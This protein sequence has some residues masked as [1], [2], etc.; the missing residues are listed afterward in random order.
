MH[1]PHALVVLV[2]LYVH[3]ALSLPVLPRLTM[4]VPAPYVDW[5]DWFMRDEV[6]TDVG[7][8]DIRRDYASM[9]LWDSADVIVITW[10]A[11][12]GAVFGQFIVPPRGRGKIWVDFTEESPYEYF[13]YNKFA[14]KTYNGSVNVLM[15]YL[16]HSTLYAP[17]GSYAPLPLPLS[18]IPDTVLLQRPKLA[19]I[20]VSNCGAQIRNQQLRIMAQYMQIDIIGKCG[21]VKHEACSQRRNDCY[22]QLSGEYLFYVAFENS[23][24]TDYVTEKTWRNSLQAGMVPIVWSRNVNYTQLLPP[25]SFI[26]IGDFSSPKEAARYIKELAVHSHLYA[27]YHA[28]RKNYT[29]N[30][31][32]PMDHGRSLCRFAHE[33][34]GT[35]LAPVDLYKL[36]PVS[37]CSNKYYDEPV[38]D[39]A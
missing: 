28:W 22:S 39:G 27:R 29:V 34:R 5:N 2:G 16:R 24:C 7:V 14:L 9:G 17:Y 32:S 10:Q 20:V 15:T 12:I 4:L 18:D 30:V 21:P 3:C 33:H 38:I 13:N 31:A 35:E 11:Y 25:H 37:S 36:R 19:V 6:I 26:S 23:D 8:C 1:V